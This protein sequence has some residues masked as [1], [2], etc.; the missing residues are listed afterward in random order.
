LTREIDDDQAEAAALQIGRSFGE[1]GGIL[2]IG[3]LSKKLT[4]FISKLDDTV[5][6]I[7]KSSWH[8]I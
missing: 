1:L 6:I 2:R 8:G 4:G 7:G 5:G 3:L